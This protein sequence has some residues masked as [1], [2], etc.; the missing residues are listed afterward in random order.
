MLFAD[1]P[2]SIR[3][4][5]EL[6]PVTRYCLRDG[7][8][9]PPADGERVARAP[10]AAGFA[11]GAGEQLDCPPMTRTQPVRTCVGCRERATKSDLLRVIARPDGPAWTVVPDEHGRMPG[12]GAHLHPRP[13]CLDQAV[14][15]R[16]LPRAL[17]LEGAVDI[18][19][20]HAWIEA[21]PTYQQ[22]TTTTGRSNSS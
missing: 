16:A 2:D 11:A 8:G 15:R 19:A 1:P 17:R 7:W 18:S 13:E 20:V 12:R 4:H 9:S 5:L 6:G 3:T 14:R 21:Q 22:T 10:N